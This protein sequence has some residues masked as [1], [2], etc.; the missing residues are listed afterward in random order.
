MQ[1]ASECMPAAILAGRGEALCRPQVGNSG[2]ASDASVT[3]PPLAA[4]GRLLQ[5]KSQQSLA[6]VG[7]EGYSV[8]AEREWQKL[9]HRLAEANLQELEHAK[10]L[11]Q[12]PPPP[13]LDLPPP[14]LLPP[15]TIG[16]ENIGAL[17]AAMAGQID[18]WLAAA[19]AGGNG[20]GGSLADREAAVAV[21]EAAVSRL[22][23]ALLPSGD[24]PDDPSLP[25]PPGES[26]ESLLGGSSE[27]TVESLPVPPPAHPSISVVAG[28]EPPPVL[29]AV[30]AAV[31][32]PFLQPT[33]SLLP[34]TVNQGSG[35]G[36][37]NG[38]GKGKLQG[39]GK[40]KGNASAPPPPPVAT[41]VPLT[42]GLPG[43]AGP[44]PVSA[45]A[46]GRDALLDQI[47]AIALGSSSLRSV[48][49]PGSPSLAAVA[50][51]VRNESEP[52]DATSALVEALTQHR[53]A[54]VNGGG[55]ES[56]DG[57]DGDWS[58]SESDDG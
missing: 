22:R 11:G 17:A 55:D 41:S 37:G 38:K 47:R 20:D 12:A 35:Q 51:G 50:G 49:D 9:I 19:A 56:D 42:G 46:G 28:Q 48:G 8:S 18:S 30:T 25:E 7:P 40:G 10:A 23:S 53:N 57:S 5:L 16:G 39:T 52:I 36:S 26:L 33:Q 15:E 1:S 54:M 21:V 2:R 44:Q 29:D 45:P 58:A 32:A 31:A 4:I 34:V 27:S 24:P 14:E 43:P 6:V 3:L 13:P